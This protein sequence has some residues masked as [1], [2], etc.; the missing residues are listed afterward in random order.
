MPRAP[1]TLL[2][3]ANQIL[4]AGLAADNRLWRRNRNITMP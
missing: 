3:E 2:D 1:K 4:R